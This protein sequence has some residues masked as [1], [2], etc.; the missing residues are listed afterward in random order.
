MADV[1]SAITFRTEGSSMASSSNTPNIYII[2]AQSTG[3]TT[4][5]TALKDYFENE[6]ISRDIGDSRISGPK[7]ITEVARGVLQRHKFTAAD[8]TSSPSRALDLQQLILQAQVI[9]ERAIS[10]EGRWFISDRSGADPIIYAR[11]YVGEEAA[12][13]LIK[14]KE[15]LELEERMKRSLVVVCESGAD[16]LKDDGVRLMP[17]SREE[18]ISFHQGFCRS[19]DEWKVQYEI[20]PITLKGID[21]RVAFVLEKWKGVN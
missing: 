1:N 15:W 16:W 10:E 13:K 4:L 20:L 17:Q 11:K 3:K 21:E 2:G 19:L 12:A 9:A 8:I 14:S 18:W 5:V 6:E 7:I